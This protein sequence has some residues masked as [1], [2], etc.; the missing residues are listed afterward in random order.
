MQAIKSFEASALRDDEWV[1]TGQ[2][3]SE[4]V[5]MGA[6]GKLRSGPPD[7]A[8]RDQ[9]W[10]VG[11]VNPK[12]GDSFV[13]LFLE[14]RGE[15]LPEL[16][17]N[18]SPLLHYKS[19]GQVWSRYPLP[20]KQ[21]PEGATLHQKNV[22]AAL[23]FTPENGAQKIEELRHS[24]VNPI[25][26]SPAENELPTHVAAQEGRLARPGEAGDSPISKHLLWDALRDCKD[27][28]MYSANLSVVDLGLIRDL[29]VRDRTVHV[30]MTM[31]HRG[32]PRSGYFAVGSGGNSVPIRSRLLKIPG[33]E[34]VVIENTWLPGWNST[35]LSPE[36]R[37]KVQLE[38]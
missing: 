25:Q 12:S 15:G 13:G 24:L 8:N 1:F 22:Y 21:V 30:L 20:V 7:A 16:K 37:K 2:P 17:H 29:R 18:A 23:E 10:A 19:H 36:G 14:H 27:E 9:V 38:V 11:F 6:D 5:W 3:F 33:V 31:P 4:I 32:R 28:Q 35:Q 26:L 34:N